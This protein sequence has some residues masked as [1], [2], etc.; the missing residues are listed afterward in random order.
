[1]RAAIYYTPEQDGDLARNAADWLGRDP[2]RKEGVG[3]EHRFSSQVQSPAR[4][5]FH[6]T[7]KAPFRLK[8]DASIDDLRLFFREFAARTSG[9]TIPSLVLQRIGRF[10]ALV[11]AQRVPELDALA[12][13]VVEAFEPFRAP[14]TPS[15]RARRNPDALTDRQR[16]HLDT[17]GYPYV[18][19]EFRF[20]MTLT[21]PV[22]GAQADEIETE[23][24]TRF[25]SHLGNP[26]PIAALALFVEPEEGGPFFV[27]SYS[28]LGT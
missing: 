25:A 8:D 7:L 28:R 19:D 17:W 16:E 23:L 21:G 24:Q 22:T 9:L 14:L 20:H 15:D 11:P 18:M 4:Y 2:F 26:H 5:G 27:D 12:A 3:E 1:M 13:K 10:F 6:A